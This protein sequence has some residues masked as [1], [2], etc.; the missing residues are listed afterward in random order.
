M[1]DSYWEEAHEAPFS[2]VGGQAVGVWKLFEHKNPKLSN[3]RTENCHLDLF[4]SDCLFYFIYK[5]KYFLHLL[6]SSRVLVYS[7]KCLMY[8]GN[9][10]A[11]DIIEEKKST[12]VSVYQI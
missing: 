5:D 6:L 4:K 11:E 10:A 7:K 3:I 2:T 1:K 9:I 8:K 12:F